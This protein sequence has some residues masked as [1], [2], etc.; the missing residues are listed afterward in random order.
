MCY[1]SSV[2]IVTMLRFPAEAKDIFF[3]CSNPF[4]RQK[5]RVLW[6]AFHTVQSGA[7]EI[8]ALHSGSLNFKTFCNLSTQVSM[9]LF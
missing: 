1:G 9:V 2:R 5:R 6:M 4:Y 8:S 3:D 7:V